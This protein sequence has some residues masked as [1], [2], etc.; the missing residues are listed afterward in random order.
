MKHSEI[1]PYA[2]SADDN[3]FKNSDD[4]ASPT[5]DLRLRERRRSSNANAQKATARQ[6]VM[7]E[8]ANNLKRSS[9]SMK[10][11]DFGLESIPD[12]YLKENFKL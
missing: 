8:V 3:P 9:S 7:A 5:K 2:R 4:L 10:K 11:G 6:S 12:A 1:D